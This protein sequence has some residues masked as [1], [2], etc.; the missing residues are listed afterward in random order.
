MNAT[1]SGC[2]QRRR[3]A[4]VPI[5]AALA[6]LLLSGC[7]SDT[8]D[9]GVE[10]A[11]VARAPDGVGIA[12]EA[13]SREQADAAGPDLGGPVRAVVHT[14]SMTVQV[15]DLDQAA[16]D[17]KQWVHDSDGHVFAESISSASAANPEVLLTLKVPVDVYDQAL[18]EFSAL[19][20]RRSLD[21]YAEDV[22]EEVIDV[23]SRVSSAEVSLDRLR[24][25][26]EDASTVEE[27]LKV[28]EQLSTRQ[29]DLESLQSRQDALA[30][31]TAYGTVELFLV[32]PSSVVPPADDSPGFLGGLASGWRALTAAVSALAVALG[33][34]LP[35]LA[36]AAVLVLP[37]LWLRRRSK[38]KAARRSPDPAGSGAA[39][40]SGGAAAAPDPVGEGEDGSS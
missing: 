24:A 34:L 39:A 30:K 40:E 10:A 28:E 14:A 9:A 26:L 17:A 6:A 19:G 23:D 29:A 18:E 3:H 36:V 31:Q 1:V 33:W 4:A 12:E 7:A 8:S 2:L 35:F 38:A 37:G 11:S 27:V 25:L 32:L 5:T 21:R 20:E 13:A 16:A 22:T 15:S